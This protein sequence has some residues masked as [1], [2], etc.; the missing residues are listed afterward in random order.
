MSLSSDLVS[1]ASSVKVG[2]RRDGA[3]E[4]EAVRI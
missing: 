2:R 4:D 1:E 3:D